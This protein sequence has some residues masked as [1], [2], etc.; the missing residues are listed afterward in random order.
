[1]LDEIITK[2]AVLLEYEKNFGSILLD[3]FIKHEPLIS[4]EYIVP[5]M[6]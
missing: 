1:M 3:H 5:A 4:K 2:F 6:F